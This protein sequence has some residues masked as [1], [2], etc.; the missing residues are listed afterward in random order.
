VNDVKIQ[1]SSDFLERE[2]IRVLSINRRFLVINKFHVWNLSP[3]TI[4]STKA[5]RRSAA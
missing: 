1:I 2:R 3:G 4:K 5:D